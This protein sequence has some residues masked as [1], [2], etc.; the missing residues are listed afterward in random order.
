M[1]KI[2]TNFKRKYKKNLSKF[3]ANY[4]TRAKGIKEKRN[5]IKNKQKK[6]ERKI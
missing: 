4:F 3:F 2:E 1:C 6:I 5:T